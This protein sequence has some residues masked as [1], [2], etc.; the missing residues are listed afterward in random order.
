[1][2]DMING[3]SD[4]GSSISELGSLGLNTDNLSEFNDSYEVENLVENIK[5]VNRIL[6][7]Q[8]QKWD[9]PGLNTHNLNE[10]MRGIE[11]RRHDSPKFIKD[12]QK[13]ELYTLFDADS[14]TEITEQ[15]L[16][17][18]LLCVTKTIDKI[19][20]GEIHTQDLIISKQLRMDITRYKNI[21]PHVACCKFNSAMLMVNDLTE[22]TLYN[23]F[24]PIP[25]TRIH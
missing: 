6:V 8:F 15:T 19:M 9:P 13:E 25:D 7:V 2:S 20:T 23:T 18:A 4:L 10:L 17:N 24:T 5:H 12:F 1:M 11:T 22:M 16:D 14:S 21:F 3:K